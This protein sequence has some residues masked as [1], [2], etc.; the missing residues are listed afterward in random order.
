MSVSQGEPYDGE[1]MN[2]LHASHTTILAFM[3]PPSLTE[4][5]RTIA[6]L[7][8]AKLKHMDLVSR[9]MRQ[10]RDWFDNNVSH[11]YGE[12]I[13]K[14][15]AIMTGG[16]GCFRTTSSGVSL[17]ITFSSSTG[18]ANPADTIRKVMT[19]DHLTVCCFL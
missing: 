7:D 13:G 17:D 14:L 8:E 9:N 15:Y 6:S 11:T 16:L 4:F 10:I 2:A 5:V 3:N 18:S 1:V 19:E 12:I